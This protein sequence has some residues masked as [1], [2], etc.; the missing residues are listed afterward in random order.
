[1]PTE[2]KT[3]LIK[4]IYKVNGLQKVNEDC[5]DEHLENLDTVCAI[6]QVQRMIELN[7][8]GEIDEVAR[9]ILLSKKYN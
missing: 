6:G 1:M 9:F 3:Q 5:P 4:S 7:T 8:Q 2:T